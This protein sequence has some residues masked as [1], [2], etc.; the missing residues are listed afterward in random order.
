MDATLAK[1]DK[2][3]ELY[4]V[5]KAPVLPKNAKEVLVKIAP[6]LALIFGLL[7]I[8]ALLA[9]FGLGAVATPFL[10]LA[11]QRTI[12]FWVGWVLSVGQVTLELLAVKPLFA[13]QRKG[14]ELMFYSSLLGVVYSLASFSLFGLVMTVVTFYLLY[15]I[16]ASYK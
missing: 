3:L 10:L 8:P 4:L 1:L 2:S 5:K 13:K 9:V 11:G 6:W 7:A 16:K 15:Q 12:I 14:W